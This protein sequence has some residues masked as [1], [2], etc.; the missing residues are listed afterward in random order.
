MSCSR[1][2]LSHHMPIRIDYRTRRDRNER[3]DRAFDEQ[4]DACTEAYMDWNFGDPNH[5]E[6]TIPADSGL[7]TV[8]VVGIYGSKFPTGLTYFYFLNIIHTAV[9][10]NAI[11]IL[12][13]DQF[14]TSALVRQGII[15]C[16]P[17]SPSVGI[18]TDAL[19]LYRVAN[20]RSPHLSIQAFV[21]TLC[22]LHTVS[23]A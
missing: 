18:T 22:D 16:S 20:L 14:I 15:P 5:T 4:I 23:L 11:N 1:I 2:V 19:E 6:D 17:I 13:T 9:S 7:I 8:K 12:P 21:K 3:R 10:D